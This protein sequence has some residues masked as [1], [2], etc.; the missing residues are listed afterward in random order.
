MENRENLPYMYRGVQF[1]PSILLTLAAQ[2]FIVLPTLLHEPL[3]RGLP[4]SVWQ[5]SFLLGGFVTLGTAMMFVARYLL[6]PLRF[7]RENPF[8]F[9]IFVMFM[10]EVWLIGQVPH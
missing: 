2:L 10:L 4:P 1:P 3:V 7:V 6:H 5:L 8:E 9:A